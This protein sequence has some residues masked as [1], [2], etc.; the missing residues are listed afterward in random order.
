M[1]IYGVN[2]SYLI[3]ACN[4]AIILAEAMRIPRPKLTNIERIDQF[5]DSWIIFS[6]IQELI[7]FT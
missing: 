4:S 5:E 6:R 1:E 3:I 2:D 7:K